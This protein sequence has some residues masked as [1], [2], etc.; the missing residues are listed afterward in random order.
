VQQRTI[1]G[2]PDILLCINGIFVGM[3]L[4]KSIDEERDPLQEH[5]LDL[6]N[7]AGGIGIAVFPENWD[8]AYLA[9]LALSKGLQYD[10]DQF[11][12]A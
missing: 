3:E 10:R 2:T 1:R 8:K 12:T 4:K 5:N 7:K 11:R 9:L 6:I